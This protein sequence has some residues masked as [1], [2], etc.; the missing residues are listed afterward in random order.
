MTLYTYD[1]SQRLTSVTAPDGLL[2]TNF[3]GA[4]GFLSQQ[5]VIGYSTNSYI[6]SNDLVYTHT[7]TLGLVTT[8]LYDNLQR[9]TNSSDSRGAIVYVYSNLDLVRVEDRMGFTNSFGYDNMRRKISEINALGNAT[10]YSYCTCGSL[11]S[12][13]DAVGNITYFYYDNQ[14]RRINTVYPDLYSVT[15]SYNLLGQIT[16]TVDSAGMSITNGF[17]NQGLLVSVNIAFGQMEATVYDSLDRATNNVDANGVSISTTNDVLNRI[18]ARSYPDSGVEQFGYTFNVAG[19]TSY[20]N[21][22]NQATFYAYDTLGRKTFETNANMEVTRF[23]YDGAGDLLTLTDGKNQPTT[24]S[25]DQF[26]R[27]TNKVDAASN[28]LL[29]Y[30]Y[31]S[32][33]RLTN[34]LSAAKGNTLYRYDSVGNLT[35][36]VYPLSHSIA[37]AYDVLNRLTSMADAVGTTVYSYDAASQLL[38]EGG[39]WPEDTVNFTY[40]NRLRTGLSVSAPNA[41]PW[42]E[43]YA[44]DV[45]RR[46]TN[47]TSRAGAFGYSYASGPSRLISRLALPNGASITNAYDSVARLLSTKLLN[48]GSTNLDSHSYT[49]N[50]ASQRTGLTNTYGDYRSYAYDNIGQLV[51]AI[52]SESN[53]TSRLNEQFIYA[54]DAAHNLNWRTNNGLWENF[55]VNPLNELSNVTR[56][57]ANLTVAG[58]TTSLATNVTVNGSAAN[59]YADSTFAL[60]GFAVTNGN[61]TFTAV[62]KDNDGRQDTSSV[63]VNLPATVNF[64]YDLNG[65]LLTNGTEVLVYDDE[66]ELVTNWVPTAWKSEFVY[67]GKHR[68]R[69]ERDY[70]W[71][72]S[73][74][75]QTNETH[76]I[77]DG[78]V[79]IQHRDAN[80]LPQLTLTRGTDLSGSLQGAGGIGGLLAITQ[81]PLLLVNSP[82]AHAYYHADG[83]GNVTML[84]NANQAIVAMAEYDPYGGF[85][86]LSGPMASVNPYWFSSKP[87]HWQSG[88]YDF[89][90]R[91]YVPQLDRW[92]NRDPIGELGGK[93]LYGFVGNQ[94][95]S[96]WDSLGL[97]SAGG[98]TAHSSMIEHL[99]YISFTITCP[100][101]TSVQKVTI[102]YSGALSGLASLG[103]DND[104][105]SDAFQGKFS[106]AGDLGG[107]VPGYPKTP[108]CCGNPVTVRAYM[109]TRLS[110]QPYLNGLHDM[111]WSIDGFPQLNASQTVGAYT[112]G[113]VVNYVCAKCAGGAG[114]N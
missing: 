50:T 62:A 57:T 72:G 10:L 63:T 7:D 33:N 14:G 23:T 98:G 97:L 35:N 11:E 78:N 59:L 96:R 81:N 16:N 2:T 36:V 19:L 109:R 21:Q 60:G 37:M 30:G 93:N 17:N 46:L 80:N 83:N 92:P 82:G 90:Y 39:L 67:D 110:N 1:S 48:S 56:S 61:N 8:N 18:R 5:I 64:A 44:Y 91:W 87:I 108:N 55:V 32:D 15:N 94:P 101:G 25:Y 42:N 9:L 38:R 71:N 43:A 104:M 13:Q 69:I 28:T 103:L 40:Q 66:N 26:G 45:A 58:T 74:W 65:N 53:G 112:A 20:T 49:Y 70:N 86:S 89:L 111:F 114:R 99:N 105:L 6:Y 12:V 75:T 27:V 68:R 106:G 24:W 34:R 85:L 22:L 79:V 95:L 52:G 100:S 54:Y 107:L 88:K 76:F 3:Y 31:D 84:I 51:S 29:V 77:Y 47:V 113:T 73:S 4:D 102:D 41:S